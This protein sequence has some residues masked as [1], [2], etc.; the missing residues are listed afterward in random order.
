MFNLLFTLIFNIL[1]LYII[2]I[3]VIYLIMSVDGGTGNSILKANICNMINKLINT[4]IGDKDK[5]DDKGVGSAG[6]DK[7]DDKGTDSD[8]DYI[9][10]IKNLLRTY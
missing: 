1:I 10:S 8:D 3:G 9:N 7:V 6:K 4:K 2:I 5:V